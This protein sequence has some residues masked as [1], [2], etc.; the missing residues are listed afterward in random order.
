M[1][2]PTTKIRNVNIAALDPKFRKKIKN[3]MDLFEEATEIR[4]ELNAAGIYVK[5]L[6]HAGII[7]YARDIKNPVALNE[8]VI[9]EAA[10]RED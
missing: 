2:L 3:M 1:T 10:Q 4:K 5:F 6:R 9:E 8:I 7:A